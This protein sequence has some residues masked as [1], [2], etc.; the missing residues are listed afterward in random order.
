MNHAVRTE[1]G[2]CVVLEGLEPRLLLSGNLLMTEFMADN[3]STLPDGDGNFSDWIEIY[4]PTDATVDLDG[5]Y[6]TDNASNLT[7]WPFPSRSIGAGQYMVV[8]ASNGR[9][10]VT[11]PVNPYRDARGNLHTSFALSSSGEYLALVHADPVPTV[12]HS[13]DPEF[14]AQF[15]NV[16]Y[17][18]VQDVST[19]LTTGEGL[20]WHVPTGPAQQP[21]A[22][23]TEVAYD[24]SSWTAGTSGVGYGNFSANSD[25]TLIHRWGF[26]GVT[27]TVA[28]D[29]VSGASGT[30]RGGA[31]LTGSGQLTL[32]GVDDYVDLPNGLISGLADVTI[33]AWVTWQAGS[34]W[35]RLFDFGSSSDGEVT[36]PGGAFSATSGLSLS[37]NSASSSIELA[38]MPDGQSATTV[39]T[40]PGLPAGVETHIAVVYISSINV[41]GVYINGTLR[42]STSVPAGALTSIVDVNNWIGRSNSS[43]EAN[44]SGQIDEFRIYDGLLTGQQVRASRQAGPGEWFS[45]SAIASNTEAA[46]LGVNPSAYV[47]VPFTLADPTSVDGLTLRMRYDDGFVAYLNGRQVASSNAPAGPAWNSQATDE[48]TSGETTTVA[49]IVP[50]S[51]GD[52][53]TENVLAIQGFN[54][55]AG[56]ADFL[57]LPEMT[58][59]HTRAGE[60]RYFATSTPGRANESAFRNIVSD[61][62]FSVDRGF[63]YSSFQVSITTE[64]PDAVIYYTL[65][66][67]VPTQNSGQV[68]SAP[69]LVAGTTVLRAAAHR[70]G[71]QPSNTDTQTYIFLNDVITQSADGSAP[72]PG[73]PAPGA[74]V[75]GQKIVY[76]M[77]PDIVGGVNTAQQVKDSLLSI[78]T[79][80]MVMNLDH[81]FN[82][83]SGIFVNARSDG[84]GWERP[85]SFELIYPQGAS[86]PGFPD[87]ADDGFQID[88]GVR[89]RGGYSRSGSNPKHAF[90]LF[91]RNQYGDAKLNYPLFGDEGAD[92][93]DKVDLR[94]SQNYSW[95]FGGPNNNT[96]VRDIYSR[97]L[98]GEMGHEYTRGRYYH[99]YINGVYWGVFQ[100][101]ERPEANFGATYY[102]GNKD[103][104]DVIKPADNRRVFAT[105][106]NLAAYNRL[107]SATVSPGYA[108][109]A[110]YYRV[111]GMNVDGTRNPAYERLLDVDNIIDYMIITYYTG[112]RDGPGSWYTMGSSGPNN[113]FA[114]YNRENPDGFKF[115][116]HDSEHSLGTGENNMVLRGGQLLE[117][118][119]SIAGLQDRFAP[120]WLHEQLV[121]NGD[122]RLRFA[123]RLYEVLYNDGLLTYENSL[124]RINTR[125]AQVD[126]AM[127]AESA[128]WGDTKASTPM[129]Q[130]TWVNEVNEARNWISN[131][132]N[133]L[134]AQIRAVGWYPNTNPPTFNRHGGPVAEGFRAVLSAGAGTIWYTTDGS[135][136][137]AHDGTVSTSA[138]PFN[139]ATTY[140]TLVAR[141]NSA[142]G[143]AL[144]RFL[145]NGANLDGTNWLDYSYNDSAWDSGT[146][147]LGYG[148][149]G[150]YTL[151]GYVD[152]DPVAA[153]V[154]KNI[155]TY[156][157]HKFTVTNI[158]NISALTVN[159]LRDD[160]AMITLNG[161]P[162]KRTNMPGGA[163]TYTTT[164]STTGSE[165]T[166]YAVTMDVADLVEGDNVIC[167]EI[168]QVGDGSSDISFNMDLIATRTQS[169]TPL[170]LNESGLVAARALNGAEWSPLAEADFFVGPQAGPANLAITE[171]NYH[172]QDPTPAELGIGPTF[173]DDDFEFVELRNIGPERIELT[174]V[175]FTGDVTFTFGAAGTVYLDPGRY[176]VV[177][178]N[179][180]AFQARYG[181][182]IPIAGVYE[183]SFGNAGDTVTVLGRLGHTIH[184]FSYRDDGPWPGRADGKGSTLEVLNTRGN[185]D[186]DDNWRSSTEY[187]G[188]PGAAGTGPVADVVINEVLSKPLDADADA[189]E[190][191]NATGAAIDIGGWF[192][193]DDNDDY[194]AFEIP[195]GTIIGAGGFEVFTA[196]TDFTFALSASGEEVWL[197]EADGA[198]NLA[199]FAD[200]VEFDTALAGV[201][202]G[203]W[204]DGTGDVV[205]LQDVTLGAA[206]S[207]P[208]VGRIV[209]NEI[210]ANPDIKTEPVEFI[211]LL[212]INDEPVDIS[213]WYF[214]D[215]VVYTFPAGTVLAPG[216][217]ALVSEDPAALLT[218]YGVASFGPY[219]G[220]LSNE[221]EALTLRD[222]A[223]IEQDEVDYGLGFPWPTVGDVPG[224]SIELIDPTLDNDLGGSWRASAGSQI[225]RQLVFDTGGPWR[226]FKG[227][228]EPSA[229]QGLWRQRAPAYDDSSW[230]AG[231]GAIGYSSE[232]DELDFINTILTDMRGGYT[233]VYFRKE[234]T[235]SA[236]QIAGVSELLL[237]VH[238]DDAFNVWINGTWLDGAN[239]SGQE[240]PYN[241]TANGSMDNPNLVPL[242]LND[243]APQTYLVA[244]TNVIAVQILNHSIS[245][246]SDAF[247]DARLTLSSGGSSGVTPGAVNSVYSAAAA[248]QMRQVSH[249]PNAPTSAQD[250][251]IT[252]KVTD[253]DGVASVTASYQAVAPGDYISKDD[254]RYNNPANWTTVTM[255]D[256]GT[257]GDATAGDDVYT[258]A[259]PAQLNR[260]LVRYRVT[261]VDTLGS[262]ITGPYW[263]DPQS[264]F[265][266][267]VYDGVPDWTG[268]VRP[269][270]TAP[271]TY[272][273]ALLESIPVY[274]LITT[275]KDHVESQYIPDST[276][277]KDW[278]NNYIYDGALVYNGVVYDHITYRPRGGVHRFKMGKN[279]WKFD[280][281]RGHYFQALDDRGVP[282]D[283]QWDKLNFSAIIQQGNFNQRGE[284]GLFEAAGFALHNM[285]GNPSPKT[286]YVHFRIVEYAD[287]SP[288]GYNDAQYDGDFQGLYLTLEQLDG[289]F[290]EEHDLPD[291][292]FYK[293]EGGTGTLNNQGPDHPTNKS[294]LN[295]FMNGYRNNPT[296]QWWQ[297]NVD[298]EDY[299]NFRAIS[300]AI[301]DYD[302]H[303]GK[304]YF[305]YHNP[306]TGKWSIVNWDLD[307]CWTT[308]YNGGGGQGPLYDNSPFVHLLDVPELRLDY[309][310]RVRELVDLLF[311]SE[312]TGMLLDE[313][314]SFV[315]TPGVPSFVDADRA[316][317][318]YNPIMSS[319]YINTGKTGPGWFYGNSPTGDYAGMIQIMKDYVANKVSNYL[320]GGTYAF[321]PKVASDEGQ[322]P[323]T[324]T[325]T[326]LGA[327][328]HPMD[329]LDFQS[330]AFS[331]ASPG[332][333]FGAMEWRIARVTDTTDPAYDP[334]NAARER[335]YEIDPVWESGE[336]AI[337]D[338]TVTIAGHGLIEGE[339]YRVRVRMKD[340]SGRWSHWSAPGQF[341]A[342]PPA[343]AV[344]TGLKITELNY[345]PYD[346]T[347]AELA[348]Q[349]PGDEP[350]G[351]S[352]FEFIELRNTSAETIDLAGVRLTTAV[353]FDF[354]GSAVTSLAPGEYMVVAKRIAAFE[355]R[356]GSGINVAGE[357]SG[358]LKNEGEL[359][360]LPDGFDRVIQAFTY[361][362]SGAWP[363]RADG[364]GSS[365]EVI[366]VDGDYNDD[367]NW[368]SSSE[369]GG[370]PG[371]AGAGPVNDVLINEV[372]AHTDWPLVDS[373]ELHNTTG[374][375]IN[376][377]GWW[378]SDTASNYRK[379]QVPAGTII[380]AGQ[381]VVFYEGHY[382]GATLVYNAATE[383]GGPGADDFGLS[384]A[385][386]DDVWLVETN[387]A[388]RLTWFADHVEF[389]ASLN[390]ESF[391]RWPNGVGDLYPM[392]TVT[393]NAANSGPR[394]GP[395]LINEVMYNEADP[396][397][398][399]AGVD[400]AD[401]EFI[402]ILNPTGAAVNLWETYF[403]DGANRDYQWKVEG[404]DF[405]VGTTLAADGV[406]VVVGFDPLV[407]PT[408]LATFKSHYGI[409]DPSVRIVG[410]F[411]G[412]LDNGGETIRLRKPD[413]PPAADTTVTPYII[414]DE[415]I[416]DD[417][418]PWPVS[419]DGLGDSLNRN[420]GAWGNFPASWA[421]TT[422]TPGFFSADASDTP[423]GVDLAAA[424]DTGASDTDN[425]T[426]LDNSTVGA[427]LQFAVTGTVAGATVTLYADGLPIGS[428]VA[429]GTS[430]TVTTTGTV[431]LLDGAHAITARQAEPGKSAS[432][433]SAPL[434]IAVD[435]VAPTAGVP[436]LAAATDTGVSDTDNVTQ[437]AAPQF[438]GTAGDIGSGVWKVDVTSDHAAS[439]TDTA[440]GTAYSVTLAALDEGPRTVTATVYDRA[441][442]TFTTA[443][444]AV[445][446]DRTA[447][448]AGTPDLNP[449]SDTG[450][451]NS[452]NITRGVDP[453]F[454]G[455]ASDLASGL[456]KV[457]VDSDD[458][459]SDV[460][461]TGEAF[462]LATL[463]TLDEGARTVTATAY[464]RAGNSVTTA[465]LAV[466]VDRTA[467]TATVPDLAAGRDTGRSDSDNV[468]QGN[469]PQFNGV[470]I[471]TGSGMWK[472]DVTS[473]DG[474]SGSDAAAP[475]YSVT[476]PAL[477]EGSRHVTATA[478]DLAGNTFMTAG[479][480]MT[481]DRTA[482]TASVPDL[483]AGSDTGISNSDDI[484]EGITPRFDGTADDAGSGLWKVDVTSDDGKSATEATGGATYGITLATLDEGS[485]TVTA[486][487]H[488]VAGNMFTTVGLA[489]T[490]DRTGTTLTW[491]GA[492]PAEWTSA[493]WAVGPVAPTGGEAMVVDSGRVTVSTDLTTTPGAAASLAI[494]DGAQGGYVDIGATGALSITG[495]VTVSAGGILN[496]DGTLTAANVNV[497]GGRLTNSRASAAAVTVNGD[498][499]L[500]GGATFVT[501]L[502]D[503]GV[504]T[505]VTTGAVTI[506]PNA[507][508][509]IMPAGGSA[510]FMAG[511]YT[512]VQAAGG[513]S[514]TFANVTGLGG[515]V[516]VNGNGLTYDDVAGTVTL[517]LDKDLNPADG[518]LDGATDVSD[519]IIW[520]NNNFT[521]GTTF[522]TGDYNGDGQTDVSD[523]IVW[524]NNNFTFATASAPSPIA[525][526]APVPIAPAAPPTNA[527][528]GEEA[529]SDTD[530][531]LATAPLVIVRVPSLDVSIATSSTQSPSSKESSPP[532]SE[533][534]NTPSEAQLEP[535]LSSGL[536][537][538]L[539]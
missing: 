451:S 260:T 49:F 38:L 96:M 17:G 289:R 8:F 93:F 27:D 177:A 266:Y 471:D 222:A 348:S 498:V 435:T 240:K 4:N 42:N 528:P 215:G 486:T 154:Q 149:D 181:A 253:P 13:Y 398:V 380:P 402:E 415:V 538:P 485:R 405:A 257:N 440:G 338:D 168:H 433:D 294:D 259:V 429:A 176:V 83:S 124:A 431:D 340:N 446:V 227:L 99:L 336:Q 10:D 206:N 217:F 64:T 281:N 251:T 52:L 145:D 202:F 130:Q 510:E 272:D 90:R 536:T 18:L 422:P 373:I 243:P 98:Q 330:S 491:D 442:N 196:G 162:P 466:T 63:F 274:Q 175:S 86:G 421:A 372:I 432:P 470:A 437:G 267:F 280:F 111:Q 231:L 408:K 450:A 188:S 209:I 238:Y 478:F 269:G 469:A 173:T 226:Y 76:G 290:L 436:D 104:Y 326:Y 249:T 91:F 452:D 32:D 291:G 465:G 268:A 539:E 44:F 400:P 347:A 350:F 45:A 189:I 208:R 234:F 293:M 65:D 19:V 533:G 125:A 399:G 401:L 78:P 504:D 72:G 364:K 200:H 375:D 159:V 187:G 88:A 278:S 40:S 362:N 286:N 383:F 374:A 367:D 141:G 443:G 265:A 223:G 134:V 82:S 378:L 314:A 463:A 379:F 95:A 51:A 47:R 310:N 115:F 407:Q 132:A 114:I 387:G 285:A 434:A 321:D 479:L 324:P 461:A 248:P 411:N 517:T 211:E 331:S 417:V 62:K 484:T 414:V 210:H 271:V 20:T 15:D 523:R 413:E 142:G 377:G 404:F 245:S 499:T 207:L 48:R 57:I 416:Y 509:D 305:Y 355:A 332:A 292:N 403:V 384:S 496:I 56:D 101:D 128:R 157:R 233:T 14:P 299:Y 7:Q 255:Y 50:I 339:T 531:S 382:V 121:D 118:W 334:Y 169:S 34:A 386:G 524:N 351:T 270:T 11:N 508:L 138:V 527:S 460:Y 317:W 529:D 342:G 186:D 304:N 534:D 261:A 246:S 439:A 216:G 60:H 396:D 438:G 12:V 511:T 473:D 69:I 526:E 195:A 152:T 371:R 494:A 35:Q 68:Y 100:T 302:M 190:L 284:Q 214:S 81:L 166:W 31:S 453:Q 410:P 333:S 535:E 77:D 26:N 94:T 516:S 279:M 447:P 242:V 258:A 356:Y 335:H 368:R 441:G 225:D 455:M 153:G 487:A 172:P 25:A 512:L 150:E 74:S 388:G 192:L 170:V 514:G 497:V 97:D 328:G 112:D 428:A 303:A 80:S 505:L 126:Q 480:A 147:R 105:D 146:G 54:F 327:A 2:T 221:G 363:G 230:P 468:T 129:T 313:M 239:V 501:D 481:V 67:T 33:E 295:A 476:L 395:L 178:A 513:L 319:S 28:V 457:E 352:D 308:T 247:W 418:A 229:T 425:V 307:L 322:Q 500:A 263:D 23:W 343:G 282:Y 191:Y 103:D 309:N 489:V 287:E 179:Q 119:S 316:F 346:P 490:V 79:I 148:G 256:D 394:I 43:T 203:R 477:D 426:R 160:G 183:G 219:T 318:D 397:G 156:F 358:K 164:A 110:N 537:N 29:S 137:R 73:W 475:F 518:N 483:A 420:G 24:D 522:R 70:T 39:S 412:V 171:L 144:W 5:W 406:L 323:D 283:T 474:K 106:G 108:N 136:P 424:S 16:S 359:F 220:K 264:N 182:G 288:T 197:V 185:Y 482:P 109:M 201:S 133:T 184:E 454:A 488:D 515:Y 204:P 495:E 521:F 71:Y 360:M 3:N 158:S 357:F 390:G 9:E 423:T 445:T 235:L 228:A 276:A 275:N 370:S 55:T 427:A 315:Y 392:E 250:V 127:I 297:D 75:N 6:L 59:S 458:A 92:E 306:E 507:S 449:I 41:M 530:A 389:G 361:D 519:R 467:P 116:E 344:V 444:L 393:L 277:G 385:E 61:T 151:V 84:M 163:V 241:G 391:G 143:G 174:G 300:M 193:T 409:T 273:S 205:M 1:S 252:M 298:L 140:Q 472:V 198:G 459:K 244:G 21:A 532:V 131:R 117:D 320:A 349:D 155:T 254:P 180:A 87:G 312:Q 30:I 135:D 224:Y 462:Y 165:S 53:G 199:R 85:A 120:H 213:G 353:T 232:A 492:D 464:D 448:T 381:Y 456:W 113:F 122:Y 212:N 493:H 37:P 218:K 296:L 66:G 419:A 354:T 365:L 366:D 107:W 102:G 430:T 262:E 506:G 520:N 89:I 337:F 345:N 22:D 329:G 237:D 236:A 376:V 194:K 46:M 58:A 369:Y 341:I 161:N 525:L 36:A 325:L 311:N 301:H 502:L 139:S 167:V 503:T 123:D